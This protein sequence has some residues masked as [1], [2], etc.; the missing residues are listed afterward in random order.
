[1]R[2]TGWKPFLTDA[3]KEKYKQLA[4]RCRAVLFSAPCGFGKSCAARALAG[5]GRTVTLSV[6]D[7][8]FFLPGSD[9]QWNTLILDDLEELED[10]SAQALC[11]LLRDCRSRQFLLLSRGPLPGWLLLFQTTGVL[12]GDGTRLFAGSGHR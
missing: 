2:N 6:R 7:L 10:E 12:G 8:G 5:A 1:M 9:A 3:L 4:D 11:G